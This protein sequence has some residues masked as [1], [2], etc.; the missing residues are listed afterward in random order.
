MGGNMEGFGAIVGAIV[1][2]A[3]V[4][5]LWPIAAPLLLLWRRS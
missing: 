4:I 5:V 3:V 2:I 1:G